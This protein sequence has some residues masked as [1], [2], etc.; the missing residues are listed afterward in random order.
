MNEKKQK[1]TKE[2]GVKNMHIGW[3][4][5]L[6]ILAAIAILFGVYAWKNMHP[7][8]MRYRE[9]ALAAG[10]VEKDA[11][12]PD[13]SVIH[14]G[15][16]PDNGPALLLI[17]GQGGDWTHYG[18]TLPALA[19]RFHVYSVDCFGH[20]GSTHDPA[21]YNCAVN[22]QALVWFLQN[23][24]KEEAYLSGHSSGGI[25]AS[26]IAA[27]APE[28]TKGL[29]IEDSPLFE[30]TPEEMTEG[31]GG[32]AWFESFLL[33][34]NYL[35]QT[36]EPEY[37]VYYIQ[38]SYFMNFFGDLRKPMEKAVRQYRTEHPDEPVRIFWLPSMITE[39]MYLPNF[40]MRFSDTFYTGSW[41]DGMDQAETLAK[42]ECPTVYI[43]A[44]VRYG[45]DGVLY[46]ANS[47]EDAQRVMDLIQDC[48]MLTIKSGHNIHCEFPAFFVD[49]FDHLPGLAN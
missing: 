44:L 21:L 43:K 25:M 41:F 9:D 16:G 42:I 1:R 32:A 35:N 7:V 22:S 11:T 36:Q 39:G 46:A 4:I 12:L 3:I 38:N 24:V 23:E 20:G 15:E 47:D 33:R 48:Q 10:Y 31:A 45:K 14:Y 13:G 49:A 29:V 5:T 30:V 18:E 37:A 19:K 34:H 2:Q 40:D 27:N 6:V 8:A 28:L 17:H 26:W